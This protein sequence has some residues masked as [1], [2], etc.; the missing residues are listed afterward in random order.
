MYNGVLEHW[1]LA[2]HALGG[3]H[4]ATIGSERTAFVDLPKHLLIFNS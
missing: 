2:E 4:E 1:L 3:N